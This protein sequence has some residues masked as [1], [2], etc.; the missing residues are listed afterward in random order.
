MKNEK[1]DTITEVILEKED[2][3]DLDTTLATIIFQGLCQFRVVI[4]ND[5]LRSVPSL[6]LREMFPTVSQG[7]HTEEQIEQADKEWLRIVDRMIEAFDQSKGIIHHSDPYYVAK[8]TERLDIEREGRIL[9][10]K[11]FNSLYN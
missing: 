4:A 3:L 10:A 5:P 9:F 2:V 7:D 1:G 11:Y 8:R 6:L